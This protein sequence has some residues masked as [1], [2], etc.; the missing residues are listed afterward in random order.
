MK[1]YIIL[2]LSLI[3]LVFIACTDDQKQDDKNIT[4][5]RSDFKVRKSLSGKTIEFDSLILRPSQIQLFD[6]FL[7]TCNQGAEKQFHIFNLNTAHKEGECIP[8]GQG[9]KEMMTPCFV[10]RNDS[11]VIFDMM[12]ST[13]FTY[14]IPE[15]TSGKEPN[16]PAVSPRYKTAM[17]QYSKLGQRVLRRILSRDESWIP[18]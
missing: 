7:V 10:N 2:H 5:Q 4:F 15:F 13:I 14:S 17:E 3:L 9:P 8:V 16:T 11:V 12:T 18:F 1:K 6:S